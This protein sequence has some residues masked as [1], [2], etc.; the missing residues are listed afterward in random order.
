MSVGHWFFG[1]KD[2]LF[3]CLAPYMGQV[4][5]DTEPVH[6][7]NHFATKIGQTAIDTFPASCAYQVLCVVSELHHPNT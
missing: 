5:Q 2:R 6:F 4:D 3:A 1:V 7:I